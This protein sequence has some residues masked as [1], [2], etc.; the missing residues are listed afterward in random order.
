MGYVLDDSFLHLGTK[1]VMVE[2]P[3]IWNQRTQ[4][5]I[6]RQEKTSLLPCDIATF[7]PSITIGSSGSNA[8]ERSSAD[9]VGDATTAKSDNL[10]EVSLL[11]RF[12][13]AHEVPM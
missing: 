12:H 2:W 1:T 7:E 10:F 3:R 5:Q 13:E 9:D 4:I 8:S 11:V 6:P